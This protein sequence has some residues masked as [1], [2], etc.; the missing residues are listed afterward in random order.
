MRKFSVS[1]II[2]TKLG[3][4]TATIKKMCNILGVTINTKPAALNERLMSDPDPLQGA[5]LLTIIIPTVERPEEFPN[6]VASAISASKTASICVSMNRSD[7]R[8]VDQNLVPERRT[9]VL[10]LCLAGPKHFPDFL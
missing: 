1:T 3:T 10:D 7:S 5:C 2:A 4:T 8:T 9:L 6:C